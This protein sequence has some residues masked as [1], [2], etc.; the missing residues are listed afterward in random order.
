MKPD[1]IQR[2]AVD[3]GTTNLRCW[4]VSKDGTPIDHAE[5]DR[6]MAAIVSGDGDFESALLDL[7]QPWLKEDQPTPV[8]AC[9]MVGARQGWIE[10]P[11]A[12]TPCSPNTGLTKAPT[13]HPQINVSI[14]AGVSQA[15]PADVMR[16]EETQIAG[17]LAINPDFEGLVFAAG[18]AG[19]VTARV[20][21]R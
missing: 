2:I 9:G 14:L 18:V 17:L 21:S 5:S 7:I 16:G 3:W 6:G 1:D 8:I 13:K 12:E 15:D 19:P 4:A 11:Y 10:V 20:A